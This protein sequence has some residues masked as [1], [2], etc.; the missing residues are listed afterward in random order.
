M[1]WPDNVFDDRLNPGKACGSTHVVIEGPEF[2]H[3]DTFAVSCDESTECMAGV[4]GFATVEL[5]IEA[6][7]RESQR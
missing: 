1:R 7:N 4:E 3:D 5:A 2:S 6:W